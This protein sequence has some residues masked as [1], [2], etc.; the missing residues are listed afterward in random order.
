MNFE[1]NGLLA[2]GW[3]LGNLHTIVGLPSGVVLGVYEPVALMFKLACR[4]AFG[5]AA[6]HA[7]PQGGAATLR[8]PTS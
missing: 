3:E 4:Q 2:G 5:E 8:C 6:G 1:R 7:S